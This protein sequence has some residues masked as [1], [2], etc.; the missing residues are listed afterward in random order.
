MACPSRSQ[1]EVKPTCCSA[2]TTSTAAAVTPRSS[3]VTSLPSRGGWGM[4]GGANSAL[5]TANAWDRDRLGWRP[6]GAVHRIRAHDQQ[7]RE[8]STD[9]DPLAV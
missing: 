9:L 6:E 7:G 3:R 4:M 5:L 1:H 8:V 2:A